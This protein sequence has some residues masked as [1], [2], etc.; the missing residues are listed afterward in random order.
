MT[1]IIP[2]EPSTDAP[3]RAVVSTDDM[4]MTLAEFAMA[5]GISIATVRR[6]IA[7]G[8]GP[9]IVH[10]SARRIGV[11]VRDYRAWLDQQSRASAE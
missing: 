7:D 4:V 8:T 11:R 1:N 6:R 9:R 2:R 3:K 10:L 5:A